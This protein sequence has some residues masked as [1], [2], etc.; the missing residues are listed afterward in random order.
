MLQNEKIKV[1]YFDPLIPY[2]N[3]KNIKL[4]S[5][6]LTKTS[7]KKYDCLIL[8]TDHTKVD[9]KFIQKNARL[10]FDTRNVYKKRFDNVIVL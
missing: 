4:K 10:I 8:I 6:N 7:I 3:I 9:Y 2:L 5:V 1:D